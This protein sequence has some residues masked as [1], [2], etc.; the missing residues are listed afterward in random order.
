[1]GEGEEVMTGAIMITICYFIGCAIAFGWG[2]G[3]GK[4]SR[5][6]TLEGQ[7]AKEAFAYLLRHELHRHRED[8][9]HIKKDMKT[10]EIAGIRAPDIPLGLWIEVK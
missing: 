9:A 7:G 8:I 2:L 1:M 10:L 4:K 5:N 3:V 6:I